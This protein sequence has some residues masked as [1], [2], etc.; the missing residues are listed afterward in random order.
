MS[1]R[2]RPVWHPGD[3]VA[4]ISAAFVLVPQSLAYA[5]LAGMPAERGLFVAALA[6]LGAAICA[7]SPYLAT[8]PTALTSLLTFG[9]LSA[10]AGPG[11]V[12]YVALGALL[13]LV[14]GAIRIGLGVVRLGTVSYLL[15]E[16]VLVGFTTGAALVIVASQVPAV[17]DAGASG[18]NPFPAAFEALLHPAAWHGPAVAVSAVS[19]GLIVAGRR[20]HR[21]FPG[22]LVAVVG[23]TAFSALTGYDGAVVGSV[24]GGLPPFSLGLPWSQLG[25]LVIPGFVIALVG[26]SE[27]AS[28]ARHYATLERRRWNPN[29]ELISQGLANLAAGFGGGFPAGGSFSRTALARDSGARTRLAGGIS[30]L[31]VLALLPFTS[32]LTHLPKA[33]LGTVVI[34][35][36]VPLIQVRRI[37]AYRRYTRLQFAVA[38]TTAALTVA[39]V[40][41]VERAVVA[42]IGLA[43]GAHLWREL[44]VSVKAWTDGETLH[45]AP[46]GVLYFASAPRLEDRFAELLADHPDAR[47]LVVH[48][49]GLGRIDITGAMALRALLADAEAAGLDARVT[50]VP[51]QAEK[52]LRRVLDGPSVGGVGGERPAE[53]ADDE[54]AGPGEV[55]HPGGDAGQD[56][57]LAPPDVQGADPD[58]LKPERRLPGSG[59]GDGLLQYGTLEIQSQLDRDGLLTQTPDEVFDSRLE[60]DPRRE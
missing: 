57:A 11:G 31:F 29:R 56:D 23:A 46:K 15:S 20:L 39:L 45:L 55:R 24:G 47:C 58:S 53:P 2:R 10:I 33:V 3:L 18:G 37:I 1:G 8:G 6:P 34:V 27:P 9:A 35:A 14:V 22:V 5:V 60:F 50:D 43:I 52:I 36:V 59:K 48:V 38:T 41:H 25:R 42:G 44:R 13:A 17:L 4:G 12:E 19:A 51:P 54:P 21:L 30:G 40:P 49:D 16:P 26:F 32:V 28:I 7:S